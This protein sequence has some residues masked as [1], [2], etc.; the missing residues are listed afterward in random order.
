MKKIL[1]IAAV[2]LCCT[3]LF[4]QEKRQKLTPEQRMEMFVVKMQKKLMLDDA[5]AA[6]FAPIYKEYLQAMKE[7]RPECTKIENPTDAQIKENIGK[8][9]NAREKAI[10]VEIKYYKKLSAIL[11]GGQ[12]KQIFC[13]NKKEAFKGGKKNGFKKGFGAE[14]GKKP[15]CGKAPFANCPKIK[16]E[17]PQMK[18][19]CP[20]M[21]GE[22]PQMK[23]ECPKMKGECPKMKG[24]CQKANACPK[25]EEKK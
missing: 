1:L 19:E 2:C 5:T 24:E 17:C 22:C 16:G 11:T 15:A 14:C 6:K 4:A 8:S 3:S 25:A 18:G 12:L 23:G 7:C 9:L 20:K 13:N 10:D 21:K